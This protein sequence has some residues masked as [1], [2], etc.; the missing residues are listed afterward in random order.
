MS[1]KYRRPVRVKVDLF[2]SPDQKRALGAV[3]RSRKLARESYAL[4]ALVTEALQSYVDAA[5]VSGAVAPVVSLPV[6][7]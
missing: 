2:L 3:K 7:S 1:S 6:V 5:R 4:R